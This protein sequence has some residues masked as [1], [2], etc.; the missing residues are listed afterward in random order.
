M[1]TAVCRALARH[2]Q[3]SSRS[4]SMRPACHSGVGADREAV[5][6]RMRCSRATQAR[7]RGALG[8]M[9][10]GCQVERTRGTLRPEGQRRGCRGVG[11]RAEAG[12]RSPR[13]RGSGG[14]GGP[15]RPVPRRPRRCPAN[16]AT[17]TN[18][19][20]VR[21]PT[22]VRR[23]TVNGHQATCHRTGGGST[24]DSGRGEQRARRRSGHPSADG[25]PL[26]VG[27]GVAVRTCEGRGSGACD[28]R[29]GSDSSRREGSGRT[30][31]EHA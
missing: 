10:S 30:R 6:L 17:N 7:L 9:Q 24:T 3:R 1:Q 29:E 21:M 31:A 2:Y 14:Q 20:A 27:R 4:R 11:T 12:G 15:E 22:P 16:H 19:R 26:G 28:G 8:R 23:T 5:R 13:P 18:H 25:R